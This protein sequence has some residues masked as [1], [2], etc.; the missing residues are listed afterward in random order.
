MQVRNFISRRLLM[1]TAIATFLTGSCSSNHGS[2]RSPDA[3]ATEGEARDA[4][5]FDR[6]ADI[7]GPVDLGVG[8]E[9]DGPAD[10]GSDSLSDVG[11]ISDAACIQLA[12]IPSVVFHVSDASQRIASVRLLDGPCLLSNLGVEFDYW[13]EG[14]SCPT[15]GDSVVCNVEVTSQLGDVVIV[16][17]RFVAMMSS[18]YGGLCWVGEPQLSV[19]GGSTT[20]ELTFPSLDGGADDSLPEG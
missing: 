5:V 13:Q 2:A 3:A 9:K 20:V 7:A 12:D 18:L 17:V 8:V 19:G 11:G 10:Q 4:G 16:P 6:A 1:I 14:Y 15:A